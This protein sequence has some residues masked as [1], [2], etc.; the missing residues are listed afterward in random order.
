[1]PPS[2]IFI[3]RLTRDYTLFPLGQP[4]LDS[5]GG[6]P[7]H[8][9]GGLA[10]W[11]D[12]SPG[13]VARAGADYP[14]EWLKDFAARGFDTAGIRILPDALDQ[15]NFLSYS[16]S[17]ELT[18]MNPV[19]QFSRL[20][21]SFPKALL[22]YHA[23]AETLPA[24]APPAKISPALADIPADYLN[25]G[26]FHICPLEL[27]AQLQ[28]ADTLRGVV[29][30][31]TL[32]PASASMSPLALKELRGLLNGVTAFLPS[33]EEISALYWGQT[34]DPWEMAAAVGAF[35]CEYVV[36]KCGPRGQLLY[37]A[38]SKRRWEIPAYPARVV[39]PTGA[40]DAFCGGFLAGYQKDHDPLE[41]ALYGN[42]SASLAIESVGPFAAVEAMP[43][44]AQARLNAL[45]EMVR[46]I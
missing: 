1:M 27:S 4:R 29:R 44:L 9:S 41:G 18:R 43:G 31:L 36:I 19:A 3:G 46:E 35:G 10:V 2:H 42:I 12:S 13:L 38:V 32:D 23:Q 21:F 45:R 6:A 22:G 37:D 14:R 16:E 40:G 20:G 28:F 33:L 34:R 8:A 15:R 30:T 39:D 5:A 24:L 25:A 11:G 26:A 17:F 7:L